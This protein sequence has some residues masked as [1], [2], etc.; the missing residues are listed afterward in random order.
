M[1]V[2][3]PR[4]MVVVNLPDGGAEGNLLITSFPRGGAPKYHRVRYHT[5]YDSEYNSRIG[6]PKRSMNMVFVCY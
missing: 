4:S 5:Y 6:D 3:V 2:V 1:F